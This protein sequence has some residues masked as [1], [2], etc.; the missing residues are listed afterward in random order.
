MRPRLRSS[1]SEALRQAVLDGAGVSLLPTFLIGDALLA[2]SLVP[3]FEDWDFGCLGIHVLYPQR[4]F[5]PLR[6]RLFVDALLAR[7]GSDPHDD[8]FWPARPPSH[9]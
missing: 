6:V 2:G 8:P 1:S 7:F 3:L 9:R 4:R 5:R